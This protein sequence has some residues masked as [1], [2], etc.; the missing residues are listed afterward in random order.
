[1]VAE[2]DYPAMARVA[3]GIWRRINLPF[4]VLVIDVDDVV[5][6]MEALCDAA[7]PPPPVEDTLPAGSDGTMFSFCSLL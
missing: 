3:T 7:F 2:Q 6:E 1:M 4:I 5:A